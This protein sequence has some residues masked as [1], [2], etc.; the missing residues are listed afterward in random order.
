MKNITIIIIYIIATLGYIRGFSQILP[1][2][3][4]VT[5][6]DGKAIPDVSIVIKPEQR[7]TTKSNSNGEFKLNSIK[8]PATLRFSRID[9]ES[10]E[11]TLKNQGYLTI[12]LS[13]KSSDLDEVI[14]QGYGTT[15]KRL[16]TGNITKISARELENQ[17]VSNPLA[18]LQGRVPG[19]V[20]TQTSGIPGSGFNIEIRGRTSLDQSLSKNDPL[21][22]IDGVVFEAGNQPTNILRSAANAKYGGS[23]GLSPLN[24]IN[25]NDIES[26]EVLKDADATAIY[27][28]RGANGVVLITTKKGFSGKTKVTAGYYAGASR[29]T[30]TMDMMNTQEYVAMRKEAFKNDGVL[31]SNNSS[32][33]GYAPDIMVWDTTRYTD[34][35]KALIGSTA[36]TENIQVSLSGGN[37][38]TQFLIGSA[39]NKEANVFSK[40]LFAKRISA[41]FNINH[42]SEDKKFNTAFSGGF[43]DNK[44]EL[45]STDLTTF[46]NMAPNIL[47]K[48]TDGSLAWEENGVNHIN[49]SNNNI[50]NPL[51][52]FL[53]KNTAIN[54]NLY[55]NLNLGYKL[56]PSLNFKVN[57]GYNLFNNDEI[58]LIPQSSIAPSIADNTK[59]SS[60]FADGATQSWLIEPQ[61]NY[62]TLIWKGKLDILIGGSWQEK[63]YKATIVQATGFANDLLLSNPNAGSIVTSQISQSLYR[64][65]ALFG[66]LGYNINGKYLFNFSLRRDGSSRF[67]PDSRR[68]NFWAIGSAWIFSEEG[69]LKDKVSFLSFGKL[70]LSYG[71][72]G[73]DQIGDYNFMK[74]WASGNLYQNAPTLN[75]TKLYNPTYQW[76]TNKK[77]E[78]AVELG[79]LKDRIYLTTSYYRNRSSNQLINYPLPRLTGTG[80]VVMNLPALVQNS[81]IE[82]MLN[83]KNITGKKFQWTTSFNATIPKNKL[84]S[85]PGIEL[86]S[87]RTLYEEGKSLTTIRGY[88]YLGVAPITGIYTFE[89]T[90]HDGNITVNDFQTLGDSAPKFFGGMSNSFQYGNYQFDIFIEFKK[91]QGRNY[92]SQLYWNWPGSAAANQPIIALN[93]W[94]NPGDIKE[95]QKFS[96]GYDVNAI[97]ATN[98]LLN[99]SDAI[100]SDASYLRIKNIAFSYNLSHAYLKKI[101]IQGCKFYINAQNIL[102][103]TRFSGMDPETQNFYVLP[104]LRTIAIGLQVSF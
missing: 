47:L 69:Y 62:S 56:L 19:V 15:S 26:I 13:E 30:R 42:S 37:E 89:D 64:Y 91:Q 53:Q 10:K 8:I 3:G 46:I 55:S 90:N 83:T 43:S 103:I 102:T 71:L 28:S 54:K 50:G 14:I 93:R 97:I 6:K 45:I 20:I 41:H 94:Q 98:V 25:P 17:P 48:N 52:V 27:G 92:L 34:L 65:E 95:V 68:S 81:G 88:R 2:K 31:P 38:S 77:L 36:Y 49:V 87:Y 51:A 33:V 4:I 61:M 67:G 80:S 84:I 72:T 5:T 9:Y 79:F 73:N 12:I 32:T 22:V 7:P 44:N 104:P 63:K 18:A 101:K 11:I 86:T 57:M 99:T 66:R 74:L 70:R 96:A 76:E 100:Y 35:K 16:N 40:D 23:G 58:S 78:G 21:F 24:S 39:F 60:S 75:P 85:F 29:V 1:L 59:A 82:F